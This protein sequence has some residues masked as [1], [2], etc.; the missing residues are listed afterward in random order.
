M[1]KVI[2]AISKDAPIDTITLSSKLGNIALVKEFDFTTA[3]LTKLPDFVKNADAILSR[4]G[5]MTRELLEA[6]PQ[7][8]IIVSLKLDADALT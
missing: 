5:D 8:K 4:V 3:D 7:L 6:M 1:W 2:A